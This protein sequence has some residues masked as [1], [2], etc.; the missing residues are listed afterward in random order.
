[1]NKHF[2][3]FQRVKS[4]SI[5]QFQRDFEKMIDSTDYSQDAN[6]H[7]GISVVRNKL[8]RLLTDLELEFLGKDGIEVKISDW[9]LIWKA[10]IKMHDSSIFRA[11]IEMDEKEEE[12]ED[13]EE[14]K[15]LFCSF[16]KV[17]GHD[18]SS[19]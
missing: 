17:K 12:E 8:E 15:S 18:V 9:K 19:C 16:G 13:E 3:N 4:A 2:E 5:R 1:M 14:K 6:I 7:S 11:L 10:L